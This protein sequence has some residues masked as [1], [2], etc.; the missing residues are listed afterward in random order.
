[1]GL[2]TNRVKIIE[3]PKS[4]ELCDTFLILLNAVQLQVIAVI[5]AT[6]L[7]NYDFTLL[8]RYSRK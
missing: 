8:D 3:H 2:N 6:G 4:N 7:I 5:V 1:M